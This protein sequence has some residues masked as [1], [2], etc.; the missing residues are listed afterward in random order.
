VPFS[1][2]REISRPYEDVINECKQLA[3]SGYK[4]ITLLGMNVNSYGADLI[5]GE[6]NIQV[7]RDTDKKYFSSKVKGKTDKIVKGFKL[8]DGRIIEPIMV[9]HLNR[10]RIPTLFPFLLSD[11]CKIKGINEVNF[12]SSNPWDFSDELIRVIAQNP[13]ISRTFH[14]A[15]QS[16]SDAVLKRMN[17]WYTCEDILILVRKLKSKINNFKLSTDIIVGFCGETDEEFSETVEMV[18]KA[19]FYKAYIS[20]YSDRPMTAAHKSLK[21]DV[22]FSIKKKRWQILEDIINKPNQIRIK[23]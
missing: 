2:G 14:I 8:S 21:D 18:K 16:G 12:M 4:K 20:I 11:V 15:V 19:G 17:R 23:N 6:N 10:L 13:N 22:A 9:K 1:R 7:F 3:Q 5:V